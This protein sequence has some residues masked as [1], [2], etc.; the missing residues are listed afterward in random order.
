MLDNWIVQDI[1]CGD[2]D[3]TRDLI[4]EIRNLLARVH[5]ILLAREWDID[6]DGR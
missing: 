1:D 6:H 4:E 3:Y 5:N 2:G